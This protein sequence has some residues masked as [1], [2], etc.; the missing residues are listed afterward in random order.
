VNFK[1][2]H[3]FMGRWVHHGG[4][5]PLILLCLWRNGRSRVEDRW[6]D[7][8]VLIEGGFAPFWNMICHSFRAS[9]TA[10]SRAKRWAH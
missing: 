4:D 1:R 7:E 8:H 6:M 3:V 5:Y 10:M 9:I 2:K